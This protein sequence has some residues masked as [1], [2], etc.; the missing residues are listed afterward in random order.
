MLS[1]SFEKEVI[2]ILKKHFEDL[3][4]IINE[5]EKLPIRINVDIVAKKDNKIY[6]IEIK[7]RNISSF[8]II[9]QSTISTYLKSEPEYENIEIK[10]ILITGGEISTDATNF[11]TSSGVVLV[12]KSSLEKKPDSIIEN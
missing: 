12:T 11:A 9:N 1:S 6:L 2:K 5:N 8:D 7:K 4:Y 10:N 3:G